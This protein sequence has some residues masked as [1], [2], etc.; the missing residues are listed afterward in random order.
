MKFGFRFAKYYILFCVEVGC[1]RSK[2]RPPTFMN[3]YKV[4]VK[5]FAFATPTI[6]DAKNFVLSFIKCMFCARNLGGAAL[7][8]YL[9]FGWLRAFWMIKELSEA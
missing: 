5:V 9:K 2:K 7:E 8:P 3:A 4:Y 6:P 1:F